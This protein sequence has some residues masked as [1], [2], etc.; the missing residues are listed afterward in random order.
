MSGTERMSVSMKFGVAAAAGVLLAMPATAGGLATPWQHG[1]GSSTRLIIGSQ[2]RPDGT[3]RLIAGIEIR[4]A[5]GWKTYWK[6]PGDSGGIPPQ[7]DW[8]QSVNL[9]GT[10]VLYPAPERLTD[11][12][13]ES[14]G[15]KKSV[16]FPVELTPADPARSLAL[17]LKFEYGICREICVPVQAKFEA[18]I[19]PGA[20]TVL[21]PELASA[22]QRVP[23]SGEMHR[24]GGPTLV[25][26]AAKLTGS[27]PSL[28]FDV[29]VPAG[30]AGADLFVESP[31]D[32]YL[33]MPKK[34]GEPA[35]GTIRFA[36]DLSSGVEI[37]RLRG[38]TLR[39]SIV[40]GGAAAEASWTV[41]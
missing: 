16:V 10:R 22:L 20:V 4:L 26:A 9:A 12:A 38:K 18:T 33:P 31:D 21:Q 27:A 39:L 11:Q 29:K 13:G 3:L 24:P 2:P 30:G 28:T 35:P 36:I 8:S 34:I 7:F 37:D 5:D 6:R 23:R 41:E 17:R 19:E 1:L 40:G 14:I 32:I 25:S 15:Y